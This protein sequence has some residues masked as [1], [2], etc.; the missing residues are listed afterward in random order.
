MN[1]VEGTQESW[2]R[3]RGTLEDHAIERH[4]VESIQHFQDTLPLLRDGAIV[5]PL[6]DA[7]PIDR[8]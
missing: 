2:K 5:E 4:D 3:F 7:C 6:P 1:G 8:P